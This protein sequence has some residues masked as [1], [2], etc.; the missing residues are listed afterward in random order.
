[1]VAGWFLCGDARRPGAG[2]KA[3]RRPPAGIGL[4]VGEDRRMLAEERTG[5]VVS[6]GSGL[7]DWTEAT[8]SRSERWLG[9]AARIGCRP[10]F[11]RAVGMERC[12]RSLAGSITTT[13]LTGQ[14]P[15]ELAPG[16]VR[17]AHAS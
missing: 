17:A 15:V 11:R 1:M 7:G 13:A 5:Q 3:G 6:V 2:V 14:D 9:W 10:S 4:D 8:G 16:C 12:G